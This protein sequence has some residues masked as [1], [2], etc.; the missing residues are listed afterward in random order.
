MKPLGDDRGVAGMLRSALWLDSVVGMEVLSM[1][2]S[3]IDKDDCVLELYGTALHVRV[4]LRGG[5]IW[6]SV[7]GL[8]EGEPEALCNFGDGARGW[9]DL[10]RLIANLERSG[11]KSLHP[12]PIQIGEEGPN[13]YLIF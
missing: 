5:W 9:S 8:D 2:R 4:A 7:C 13:A 6:L 1:G 12:R 3:A 11:I 10:R